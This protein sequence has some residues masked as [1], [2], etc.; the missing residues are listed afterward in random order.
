[1]YNKVFKRLHRL[2]QDTENEFILRNNLAS[3]N[4]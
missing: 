1:M 4:E 3:E 2:K